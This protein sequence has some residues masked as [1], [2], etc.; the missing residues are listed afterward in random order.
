MASNQALTGAQ[1]DIVLVVKRSPGVT[2]RQIATSLNTTTS[3]IRPDLHELRAA[4]V[5]RTE[6]MTRGVRYYLQER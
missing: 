5:L 2:G 6:G 1:L 4:K 3:R